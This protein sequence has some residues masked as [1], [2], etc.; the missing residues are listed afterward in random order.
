MSDGRIR[1]ARNG[2]VRLA[3]RILGD[4]D[5]TLVSA[6]GW[7]SNVGWFDE[8]SNLMAAA[9]TMFT[10]AARVL[11]FDRRGSGLSDPASRIM[12]SEERAEDLLAIVDDACV[13]RFALVATG[14]AGPSCIEFAARYP[15]RVHCLVLLSS[16]ARFSQ[17]LPDFP[18][19]F[20]PEQIADIDERIDTEWGEGLTADL[21][22]G[23]AANVPGVREMLGRLQRSTLGPSGVRLQWREATTVDVRHLLGSI[24]VPTLVLSRPGDRMVA[25]EAAAATAAGIP[26]AQ[27]DQLPAGNHASF[28]I[29]DVV[30]EK[31]LGFVTGREDASANERV[32][33]A[34]LFTDIVGSTESLSAEGDARWRNLLDLHDA[35]VDGIVAKF[36]GRRVNHTGDGILALFDGP[37]NSVRCALE[38]VAALACLGLRIRAGVH[39]GECER[40]GEEWSGMAIHVGARIAALAGAGQVLASRTIRDLCTGSGLVFEDLGPHHLKGVPEDASIYRA[41]NPR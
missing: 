5:I 22:Y 15:D 36:G 27:L 12:T 28:D 20:T 16:A 18:C 33:Q 35:T 19:G 26:G 31:I 23:E 6:P 10:R 11:V 4:G 2:D 34:I 9:T 7:A 17:D 41:K 39:I 38:L 21:L 32:L 13:D 3:Y 8:P 14:D 30:T 40:R 29:L 37:T 1:Y 25:Y 24:T